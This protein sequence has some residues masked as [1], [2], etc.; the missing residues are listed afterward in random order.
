[1]LLG[2]L[3]QQCGYKSLE[4]G[5]ENQSTSPNP[6]PKPLGGCSDKAKMIFT[7]LLF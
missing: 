4:V 6:P 3:L 5:L 1:L 7:L 2:M